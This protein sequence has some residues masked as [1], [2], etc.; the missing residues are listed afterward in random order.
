VYRQVIARI[1][2]VT[3]LF[4]SAS[5]SV[6]NTHAQKSTER[7]LRNT[8][9]I[10]VKFKTPEAWNELESTTSGLATHRLN[11]SAMSALGVSAGAKI[12]HV[13][14]MS[15]EAHVIEVA[16]ETSDAE[17]QNVVAR[18]RASS[19]I[20][21]ADPDQIR[22]P[23]Y[24]PDDTEYTNQWGLTPPSS[25]DYGIDAEGA[26]D[27]IT[28][29]SSIV[30]AVLD[31]GILFGHPDLAGRTLS[32]YDFIT[33]TLV[34]N[35]G[36]GKDGDPSD[37]GDWITVSENA[38]GYFQGCGVSGSSWHGT[39]VAGTIGAASDNNTGVSGIN[40]V[41][42]IL[43]IRVLGKCGGYDSNIVDG[44]RWA[45]GLS[46]PGVPANPTPAK[47]LNMS[48]GGELAF[49]E[50]GCP[51]IYQT[52]IDDIQQQRGAVIVVAAGNSNKN[53]NRFVPANC[54]GVITVAATTREGDRASYSNYGNVVEIAAPG[55]SLSDS[56]LS[57]LNNGT[58]VPA[59]H[60][61]EYYAGTSMAT[62]HVAGVVS[63]M[64]SL[65]GY[66][67]PNTILS[68]L[69]DT[70]TP[71]PSGSTCNTSLCGTG[72][73]NAKAALLA[74]QALPPLDKKLYLPLTYKGSATGVMR[75]VGKSRSRSSDARHTARAP[76]ERDNSTLKMKSGQ[77]NVCLRSFLPVTFRSGTSLP[78]PP[79][80]AL[81][82]GDF[83]SGKTIWN[84]SSTN[85]DPL[86]YNVNDP[87]WQSQINNGAN[88]FPRSGEWSAWF[89]SY[90]NTQEQA[91][92]NQRFIVQSNAPY[93]SFYHLIASVENLC[94]DGA[95][96]DVDVG[97][98]KINNTQLS[99][100]ALCAATNTNELWVKPPALDLSAFAGQ[101]IALSFEFKA[102]AERDSAWLIDDIT[103]S[104]TP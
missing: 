20:E 10:I 46:V 39:H 66:L 61:Y 24:V 50:S 52:A 83:D 6:S 69:R 87:F 57:T 72:I 100:Y 23:L 73:V 44:M 45:A 99:K 2:V 84:G 56:I 75:R 29:S 101:A 27:I 94:V 4:S 59:T 33:D 13:R 40:W 74:V 77:A 17:F 86:I 1:L 91:S 102:D 82:N 64:L 21:F 96:N 81:Q 32:G 48:L 43:P 47:V 70:A 67:S 79:L 65:K 8:R 89:S 18:L 49:N 71:F 80:G 41:S 68:I 31:S 15:G 76:S 90:S 63:L 62:P 78:P 53:A 30:V 104:A 38:S 25:G 5:N 36:D 92:L 37:P 54:A 3:L 26:W 35:D 42:K 12:N 97:Y 93:L 51:S 85:C 7:T 95:G 55:G 9:R 60:G 98:V 88:I 22:F 16:S 14:E 103:F 28:G 58:T 34:A 11:A 19:N